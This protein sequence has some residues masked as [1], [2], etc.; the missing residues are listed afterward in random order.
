MLILQQCDVPLMEYDVTDKDLKI[1]IGQYVKVSLESFQTGA[2]GGGLLYFGVDSDIGKEKSIIKN[3][4]QE[5][6][7]I[8]QPQYV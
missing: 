1:R 8:I 4:K 3:N 7:S 5:T 2:V 6:L